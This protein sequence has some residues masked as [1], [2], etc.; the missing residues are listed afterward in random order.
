MD[1]LR[2]IDKFSI[3]DEEREQEKKLL[4]YILYEAE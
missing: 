3:C 1:G 2:V 4:E